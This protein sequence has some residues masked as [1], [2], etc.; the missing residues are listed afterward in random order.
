MQ[1]QVKICGIKDRSNLRAVLEGG[2]AFVGLNFFAK[3][4]RV[5]T[6]EQAG[7]LVKFAGQN[8][9][10]VGLIVDADDNTIEEILQA[11]PLNMLQMHGKE[12]PERVAQVRRRFAL[13]VMKALP[14]SIKEDLAAI[15]PYEQVADYLLFDAKPLPQDDRPGGNA[16]SFDWNILKGME[17]SLPWMLA[18]GL[19]IDNIEI[20][21]RQSGTQIIDISS[22]VESSP[23]QKDPAKI[24]ALLKK[25]ESL[26]L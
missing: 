2:A 11:C 14:I 1:L 6:P 19:N 4:P 3:S 17:C 18:G 7:D 23:G 20:A 24:Q 5:L 8:I 22:G 15:P 12:H 25:A 26:T 9:K 16:R 10:K 21:I 13:P